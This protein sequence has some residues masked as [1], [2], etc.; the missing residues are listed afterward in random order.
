MRLGYFIRF[1]AE[2]AFHLNFVMLRGSKKKFTAVGLRA[3]SDQQIAGIKGGKN[4]SKKLFVQLSLGVSLFATMNSSAY[5]QTQTQA[6]DSDADAAADDAGLDNSIV[7]TARRREESLLTVPQTVN[8]V[9]GAAIEKLNLTKFEDINSVV[10]GL[11]LQTQANGFTFRTTLR[12]VG[13]DNVGGAAPNVEYY[14]NDANVSPFAVFQSF[15][16]VGQIEVLR[17]PQGTL[18]GKASPS[19]SI[20]LVTRKADLDEVGGNLQMSGTSKGAINVQGGI[21]IPIIPGIA[22]I[23]IA[24]IVDENENSFARAVGG[25]PGPYSRTQ[26]G[27]VSLRVE[28]SEIF[29]ANVTYQYLQRNVG[30]SVQVESISLSQPTAPLG[31]GTN[32]LIRASDRLALS[33][34]LATYNTKQHLVTGNANLSVAGQ[35]LSYVGSYFQFKQ[36]PFGPTDGANLFPTQRIGQTVDTD[37]HT[38]NHELRMS[39]DERLFGFLDY[40][41]GAFYSR[42]GGT[43]GI[44]SPTVIAFNGGAPAGTPGLPVFA[45]LIETPLLNT[46]FGRERSFFGNLTAYLGESTEIS[47]GLRQINTRSKNSLVL[48]PGTTLQASDRTFKATVYNA[49]IKHRFTSD[50]MIYANT[51]TS[52]RTNDPAIGVFRPLTPRLDSL[53][54]L[55]GE[56]STSYEVGL[57][58]SLLDRKLDVSVAAFH[59]KFDGFLFRNT[60]AI[61]FVNLDFSTGAP[62]ETLGTFN[63]LANVPAVVDGVEAQITYRP[64]RNFYLDMQGSYARGRIKNGNIACNDANG[65]GIPDSTSTLPTVA[66]IKAASGGEAVAICS[67]NQPLSNTPTFTFTAQSEYSMPVSDHSLAFVRGLLNYFPKSQNDPTNRFD[68]VS[69]YG[70][71]NVYLGL[72]SEDGAWEVAGFVKN[73]TATKRVLSRGDTAVQTSALDAGLGFSNVVFSG[74]YVPVSFTPPREFGVSL[75]YA[76]GSR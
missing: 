60:K 11:Q 3:G 52:F 54:N 28:P 43:N 32:V 69:S 62:I 29:D 34:R 73:A 47:G 49:S 56:K 51:G 63:F 76:F 67:V 13:Y 68:S 75:R 1:Q 14:I 39:S 27:R 66:Q 24:G 17:G 9:T 26:S 50:L 72:R 2:I 58:A 21:G 15:Y 48:L 44:L 25:G 57:K 5:A 45:A 36:P 4:M 38:Q 6:P 37:A 46:G 8:V 42:G 40:T 22:A 61:S 30:T 35:K 31:F 18:R 71:L 16:D 59:Q 74:N 19:G 64:S 41:V 10:P 53:I 12:G 33:S 20:T 7:V 23:R 70:L 65:D 55:R